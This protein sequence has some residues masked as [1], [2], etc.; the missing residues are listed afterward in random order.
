MQ[1]AAFAAAPSLPARP[2]PAKL[3]GQ[4]LQLLPFQALRCLLIPKCPMATI[5]I[6]FSMF[7]PGINP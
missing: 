7:H 6:P 5:A 2:V 3:R 4:A 1:S